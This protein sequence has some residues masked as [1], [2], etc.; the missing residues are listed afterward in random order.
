[1]PVAFTISSGVIDAE[2]Q[3]VHKRKD[4]V[5]VFICTRSII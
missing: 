5:A 4:D 3:Y 1:M 2:V